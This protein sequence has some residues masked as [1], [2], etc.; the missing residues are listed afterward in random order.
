MHLGVFLNQLPPQYGGAFTFQETIAKSLMRAKTS[1]KVTG[2]FYGEGHF[3]FEN[4]PNVRFV[5]LKKETKV[6]NWA[7][8]Y[9]R[10]Q[11][12]LKSF[13]ENEAIE[14]VTRTP[15]YQA[16]WDEKIDLMWFPTQAIEYVEVPYIY[17]VWDM[18]HRLQPY[19][20]EVSVTG[21][22]FAQ[23]EKAFL[24]AIPRAAY[25]TVPNAAAA[26]ELQLFYGMPKE[27]I[28]QIRQ[29]V[30]EFATNP[31]SVGADESVIP[32]APFLFYPAQFWPHKN[33]IVILE[34]LKI[35]IDKHK[36][37][38][39]VVFTG[40]DKGNLDYVKSYAVRL[41][42]ESRVKFLG[43][44]SKE[45]LTC[46]YQ[47]AF[48][49]TFS[50]F[51]GP[52]NMPP[53]EAFAL[54]CPVIA[55]AVAGAREQM[56]DAALYFD[57][58]NENELVT[59]ILQMQDEKGLREKLVASGVRRAADCTGDHYIENIFGIVNEFASVRRCWSSEKR[60]SHT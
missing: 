59:A 46:L 22:T 58:R 23:R 28:R 15:L 31:T 57:P 33:Q 49:L 47:R 38:L 5:K 16:A 19:F 53:M 34:A 20:P 50:S 21:C 44:V 25:V 48:A 56:G 39:C 45:T 3:S 12:K 7:S 9:G 4:Q 13:L 30:S 26:D 52:E 37:D 32:K 36:R 14:Q 2:F 18:Q 27:R 55:S 41:G 29:P 11:T 8:K 42:I 43:F 35:L 10:I 60:Y 54:K 51:F 24:G 6:D 40:S 1:H 17:T